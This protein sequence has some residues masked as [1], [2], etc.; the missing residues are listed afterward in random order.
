MG[1][2][3]LDCTGDSDMASDLK[4]TLTV[5]KSREK[6][7]KILAKEIKEDNG[8]YNTS[9]A[10]NIALCMEEGVIFREDMLPETYKLLVSKLKELVDAANEY[11]KTDCITVREKKDGKMHVDAYTRM[12]K[13]VTKK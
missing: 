8:G 4:Y 11:L 2:A 9:G 12:L 3:G 5:S 6:F 1:Y 13:F 10:V 7:P